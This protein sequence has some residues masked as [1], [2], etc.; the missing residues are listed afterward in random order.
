MMRMHKTPLVLALTLAAVLG[1]ACG[2]GDDDPPQPPPPAPQPQPQPQPQPE[3]PP[4]PQPQVLLEESFD[5]LSAL[6]AGW[7]LPSTNRGTVSVQDGSLFI[8]GRAH[9]TAMTAVM[10]P[11]AL[12]SLSNYRVDM[13]FTFLESNNATRWGSIMYRAAGA[14]AGIPHE[15]YYQFAIR[16]SASAANGTEFA[17]R[18]NGAWNV[19]GTKAFSENIDPGKTYTATVVVHGNRVRQYLDGVLTHDMRLDE[20]MAAGGIGVQTT[21]MV[22]RVDSLKVTE[23]LQALPEIADLVVVQEPATG[24]A[25]APTLVQAMAAGTDVAASAASNALYQ[26]DATLNLS[27]PDGASLGSLAQYLAQDGRVTIPVLRIADAATVTALAAFAEQRDLGDVT[28]LSDNVELLASARQQLPAVRTAVDFSQQTLLGGSPQDILHVVGA[29]NRARAKIAVLPPGM[30]E[31]ATVQQLQRLLITTWARSDAA[32]PAEAARVLTTGVHGVLSADTRPFA[33]VLRALPTGT[34]LRKPLITGHRGM[35]STED[36]NTL[37]GARAAVA[38]GADAVENDIY[39][40]ADGHLVVMHDSTVDRTTTGSGAIESLT[41]DQ[42]RALRTRPKG[43]AVPTLREFFQEFKGQPM[44]HFVEIKSGHADI[45]PLLKAELDALGVRDQTVVISFD[46]NQLNRMGQQL[47]ELTTG[48]L[49]SAG[50]GGDPMVDLRNFLSATQQYSSTFNPSHAN[51]TA[52]AM[53]AAKHRGITFWPWTLNNQDDFYRFYSYGTHGITTD[54]AWWASDLPVE[55]ASAPS[56]SV[57][58]GQP[59]G[60]PLTLT[61]QVGASLAASSNAVAVLESSAAFTQEPDG[62]LRFTTPGTATVLPGYRHPLAA[63]RYSYV[64]VGQPVSVS[65]LP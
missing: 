28:L 42:V 30:T 20:A 15:P 17:L 6:P 44:T 62:T 5:G 46:G 18:A 34:L 60:M 49:N 10:L 11:A 21:G 40:T 25:M 61:T 47:P 27:A 4:E 26:L 35:P 50:G 16:K 59:F 29:T 23:Q 9:S 3:P 45:V 22:M 1:T 54:Y 36:E 41:L 55:I 52:A 48:Y 63:G 38:A 51:L 56:T 2:G 19:Q 12:Q 14:D 65:V 31:R 58:V 32:T 37:E 64:I 57:Q 7:T 33:A 39:K 53:E 24:A 43:Y 8:D 13:V